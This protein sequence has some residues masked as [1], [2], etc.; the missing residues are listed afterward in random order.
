M[1]RFI[2]INNGH[3]LNDSMCEYGHAIPTKSSF[4]ERIVGT[5]T[6][7]VAYRRLYRTP[8]CSADV[9]CR[10]QSIYYAFVSYYNNEKRVIN[11]QVKTI[12]KQK[13]GEPSNKVKLEKAAQGVA[14]CEVSA[15]ARSCRRCVATY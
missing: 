12:A 14:Q 5:P 3:L 4:Q 9:I 10:S 1:N 2:G 15:Y 8:T 6:S 11:R 13:T 7:A